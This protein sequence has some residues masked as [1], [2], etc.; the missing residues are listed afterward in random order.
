[1]EPLSRPLPHPANRLPEPNPGRGAVA[2]NLSPRRGPRVI[3]N[4]IGGI[5]RLYAP[6]RL[7]PDLAQPCGF[8][9]LSAPFRAPFAP[10][11]FGS[12]TPFAGPLGAESAFLWAQLRA[13]APDCDAGSASGR[14]FDHVRT[15]RRAPELG[16]G[17]VASFGFVGVG[18][19]FDSRPFVGTGSWD[20]YA[21]PRGPRGHHEGGARET[22]K[23]AYCCLLL[24]VRGSQQGQT[25]RRSF[26]R[27]KHPMKPLVDH[28]H[29]SLSRLP[30]SRL[31]SA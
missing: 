25:Q 6:P 24:R 18:H 23:T 12:T 2:A 5:L 17:C 4:T 7:R 28:R 26:C 9:A 13:L 14:A 29:A 20:R 3:A 22:R 1:M 21:S 16:G 8:S 10:P 19:H 31:Q 15:L 11:R 27:L 30:S